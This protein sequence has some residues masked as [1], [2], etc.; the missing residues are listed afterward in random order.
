MGEARC[1]YLAKGGYTSVRHVKND[2]L[3]CNAGDLTRFREALDDIVPSAKLNE[4]TKVDVKETVRKLIFEIR[5]RSAIIFE[6]DGEMDEGGTSEEE[7]SDKDS[8]QEDAGPPLTSPRK[9]KK[10][11][12]SEGDDDDDSDI[13]MLPPPLRQQEPDRA[14]VPPKSRL[15]VPKPLPPIPAQVQHVSSDSDEENDSDAS[16]EMLLIN[17][18]RK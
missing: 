12:E 17:K 10:A 6:C 13:Q 16:V 4:V 18:S 11:I 7:E 2:G 1:R 3:P 14:P 8:A 15:S 5:V 9:Y